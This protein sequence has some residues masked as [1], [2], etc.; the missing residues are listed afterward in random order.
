MLVEFHCI[1]NHGSTTSQTEES[2]GPIAEGIKLE[3]P[4]VLALVLSLAIPVMTGCGTKAIEIGISQIVTHPALDATRQGIIDGL[5]EEGYTEG[6]N[7]AYD[8]QNVKPEPTW[9][10]MWDPKYRGRVGMIANCSEEM[11]GA[12]QEHVRTTFSLEKMVAETKKVYQ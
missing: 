1:A 11:G 6:K 5:A 4:D 10:N 12:L 9:E 8:Y 2:R 3:Y 7:V